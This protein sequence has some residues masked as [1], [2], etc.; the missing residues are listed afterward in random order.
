MKMEKLK[1]SGKIKINYRYLIIIPVCLLI[2]SIGVLVNQ[3]LTTGDWF[4]KSIELRGGVLVTIDSVERIDVKTVENSL[5]KFG[6]VSVRETRSVK[7]YGL[8]IGMPPETNTTD[9]INQLKGIGINE[10][11]I[12]I[13][14]IGPSLGSSFWTQAQIAIVAAFILMSIVVFLMFR[15]PIP[16]LAVILCAFS[17]IISTFAFMQIFGIELSLASLAAIL[18][19]IGYSVDTDIMATAKLLKQ[20][21]ELVEKLKG[22]IKTGLT[23]TLTSIGALVALLVSYISPVLSKI[24]TVLIIGLTMDIIYTWLQNAVILRW[25]LEKKGEKC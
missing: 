9:V 13:Q 14:T 12:S 11:W 5:S 6:K 21:G 8:V 23:M 20:S 4:I 19:I 22:A 16:S 7:G 10:D 2:F 1:I 15:I 17:D 24:A 18:M 3:Y 25:Y